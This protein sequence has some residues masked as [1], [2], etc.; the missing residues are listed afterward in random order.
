MH[1]LLLCLTAYEVVTYLNSND[2]SKEKYSANHNN[3]KNKNI[4]DLTLLD[5]VYIF[6]VWYLI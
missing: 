3:I 4:I 2:T 1:I 5:E 6:I